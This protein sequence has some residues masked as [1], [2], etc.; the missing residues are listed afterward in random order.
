M[1]EKRI[2]ESKISE[3]LKVWARLSDCLNGLEKKI[4]GF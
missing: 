4:I 3:L 1:S 2:L